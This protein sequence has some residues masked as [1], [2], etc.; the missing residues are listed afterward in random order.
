MEYFAVKGGHPLEGTIAVH[1]AKNSALPILAATLLAQGESV[2]H[3]CPDLTDTNTALDI[4][5]SL[6]CR[7]RREGRTVTVD[8]TNRT[9]TAVP[10]ELMGQMRASVL[11][12]GSLL[13]QGGEAVASWP[14][15]CALGTRPIDL[16]IRA[17]QALGAEVRDQEGKLVCQTKGLRG[18]RLALPFPSVGTTE[19]AMLAACGAVGV[20]VIDNA[21]REPEIQDLQ[22]FLQG[23]G[24]DIQGAGTSQIVIR[25]GKMLHPG[26]YT[27][28]ADRIVTATY[29]CAVAAA[30]GEGEFLGADG[31]SLLPVIEALH[32][33]GCRVERE[34]DRVWIRQ[35]GIVAG[36][37][38]VTTEPYPGFPTD[39][40]PLLAAALAGG[41]GETQIVETIFDQRFRYVE[42]LRTMGARIRVEGTTAWIIGSKLRGADLEATDLRGGAALTIAALS[43]EGESVIW[44][45]SHIDRG[46]ERLED[47]FQALGGRIRRMNK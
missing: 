12:L 2:I 20:T 44:S 31:S 19:N 46:Y 43:A 7:V 15:G 33:A 32:R 6:G 45:P 40:Q 8:T 23:L 39:A 22:G 13:A 42:G 35:R 9:G 29:L 14:G 1:G 34:P 30:G 17:F 3:N 27:V 5:S 18:R 11:F 26:E 4:L 28:M 24:A 10:D 21:A 38:S 41:Q 47:A 37:G 16:H 25:G 36:I